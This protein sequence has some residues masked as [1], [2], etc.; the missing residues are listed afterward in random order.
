MKA[1]RLRA[2]SLHHECSK[3]RACFTSVALHVSMQSSHLCHL[4]TSICHV[5]IM[6]HDQKHLS[7]TLFDKAVQRARLLD[8]IHRSYTMSSSLTH[9]YNH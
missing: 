8:E 5:M 2:A 7:L 4:K 1:T 3:Q 6:C 9:V